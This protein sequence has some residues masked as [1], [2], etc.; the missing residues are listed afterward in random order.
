MIIF[1]NHGGIKN[2]IRFDNTKFQEAVKNSTF[3]KRK[4]AALTGGSEL[5]IKKILEGQTTLHLPKLDRLADFLGLDVQI[6]F[7][8]RSNGTT[9]AK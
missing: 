1:I 4:I 3:S 8:P 2:L 9:T 5:T 6:T 7:I